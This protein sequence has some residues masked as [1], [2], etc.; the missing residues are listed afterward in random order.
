V[1]FVGGSLPWKLA[2]GERWVRFAHAHGRRCH[3][4]RVGTPRRVAWARRIGADSID[5]CLPL[6]SRENLDAFVAAVRGEQA[7]TA[8]LGFGW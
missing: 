1:L 4:G 2:T 5:S 3:I 8:Q 6:W 7:A